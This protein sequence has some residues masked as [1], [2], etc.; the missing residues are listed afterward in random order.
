MIWRSTKRC[1][2]EIWKS[3][4]P[5]RFVSGVSFWTGASDPTSNPYACMA[6]AMRFNESSG[7][8]GPWG[9]G[10]G[11]PGKK[12]GPRRGALPLLPLRR[13]EEVQPVLD[14][15]PAKTEA[16]LLHVERRRPDRRPHELHAADR[17]A[18]AVGVHRA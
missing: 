7:M 8:R 1:T 17:I 13:D 3:S 10:E 15:R 9:R 16:V 12:N 11:L 18:V 14:D 4:R 5:N 2:G 6:V